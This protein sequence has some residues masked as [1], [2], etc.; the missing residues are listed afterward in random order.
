[1]YISSYGKAKKVVVLAIDGCDPRLIQKFSSG[2]DLPHFSKLIRNGVFSDMTTV[3]LPPATQPAWAA[4][5]TGAGPGTTGIH[6][7]VHVLG[8]PLD[9]THDGSESEFLEAETLWQVAEECGKKVILNYYPV[10]WPPKIKNGMQ[11]AA[12]HNQGASSVYYPK[13]DVGPSSLFATEKYRSSQQPGRAVQITLDASKDWVEAPETKS[14]PLETE[15][16]VPTTYI[17]GIPYNVLVLNSK[18]RGY[19]EVLISTSKDASKAIACLYVGEESDWIKENFETQSGT[20]RG[21][22]KFKLLEL[23]A[24]GGK[25][26]L[27]H[28]HIGSCD[29]FTYPPSLAKELSNKFGPLIETDD[30]WALLDGWIDEQSYFDQIDYEA[31]WWVGVNE[32]LL[33]N[34]ECDMLVTYVGILDHITHIFKGGIDP[35]HPDY[36]STKANKY[37]NLFLHYYKVIDDSIGRTLEHIDENETLVVLVS[38]HSHTPLH[39]VFYIN[40]VLAKEGLLKYTIEPTPNKGFPSDYHYPIDWSKTKAINPFALAIGHIFVNLKGRD[41]HGIVAPEEEYEKVQE[42]IVDLLHSLKDPRTGQTVVQLAIKKQDAEVLGIYKG[43][44]YERLGDVLYVMNS[45]Y[46][47]SSALRKHF[48][49]FTSLEFLKSFS[50]MH[51]TLPTTGLLPATFIMSGP[52]V[53]KGMQRKFPVNIIDVAPTICFLLGIRMPQQAE[54]SIIWDALGD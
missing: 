33:K 12:Y 35:S 18:G 13:F 44:G 20:R 11:V 41:P 30:I 19:D 54:G 46:D 38:D 25:F 39:T 16:I 34:Y 52:G 32:H 49:E 42:Q 31:N 5:A 15:I 47:A 53:R 37:W 24:D 36:D 27:Y 45:G 14:Y 29:G 26:K 3:T 22:F 23:S 7:S 10:T 1:M 8:E 43:A 4:I 48:K 40:H 51:G 2:G 9:V 21:A 6:M 50:G 17:S 28:H